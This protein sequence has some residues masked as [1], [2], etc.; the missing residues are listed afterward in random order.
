MGR[1]SVNLKWQNY[2]LS[3]DCKKTF[4]DTLTEKKESLV[5]FMFLLIE[6]FNYSI[7][8]QSERLLKIFYLSNVESLLTYLRY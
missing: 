7:L 4:E 3:R 5:C 8:V 6:L 1:K 2:I